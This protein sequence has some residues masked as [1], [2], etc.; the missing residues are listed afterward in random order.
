MK[1]LTK[2]MALAL[3]AAS[4][5]CVVANAQL[6]EVDQANQPTPLGYFPLSPGA[7]VGQEF[8]PSLSGLDFVDLWIFSEAPVGPAGFS[9]RIR[10]GSITGGILGESGLAMIGSPPT[11]GPTHFSFP[12]TV[13]LT[14]GATHVIELLQLAGGAGWGAGYGP[15]SGY[16]D[17]QALVGGNPVGF[18]LWFREGVAVPEPGIWTLGLAGVVMLGVSRRR[19]Q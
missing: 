2:S 3:L 10:E 18:D 13:G 7:G 6:F 12:S 14:G 9:V 16:A 19:R 5:S 11:L 8:N 4:C 1:K 17:G 15:N